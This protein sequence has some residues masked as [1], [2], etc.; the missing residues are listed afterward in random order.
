MPNINIM[1]LVLNITDPITTVLSKII[2]KSFFVI[3]YVPLG[4]FKK[5]IES[6]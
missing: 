4:L 1:D 6:N 5:L 3:Q 2:Q